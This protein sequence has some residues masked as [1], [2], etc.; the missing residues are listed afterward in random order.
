MRERL[1]EHLGR[2]ARNALGAAGYLDGAVADAVPE[3]DRHRN[4][5][6]HGHQPR[7]ERLSTACSGAAAGNG[8]AHRGRPLVTFPHPG[9][10]WDVPTSGWH[11][12]SP[13]QDLTIWSSSPT[14]PRCGPAAAARW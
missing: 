14:S 3:A 1:W 13:D 5:R 7:S 9:K 8:P 6:R 10:A 11:L 12:D 2:H 4:L